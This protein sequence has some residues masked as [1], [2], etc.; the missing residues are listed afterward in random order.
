M[1][2]VH[3]RDLETPLA[4]TMATLEALAREGKIR[5]VGV[6]NF[7]R[8]ELEESATRLGA[9]PLAAAQLEYSLLARQIEGDALP[10]AR[11]RSVAVLAY[12]PLAHGVLAG[13][14]LGGKPLPQDW[15]RDTAYFDRGNL[16]V[17]HEALARGVVPVARARGLD[18][19]QV[20]L[21]WVLAQPGI[22]GVIAGAGTPA[23]AVANAA[24]A[25]A[26]LDAGE[27]ELIS[28]TFGRVAL[29]A[30]SPAR[31][32]VVTRVRSR[33]RLRSFL[34]VAAARRRGVREVASLGTRVNSWRGHATG[35]I[36]MT[37]V[38]AALLAVT[39][40][41][42]GCTAGAPTVPAA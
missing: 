22:T 24:A 32:G 33:V 6:S 10:W 25:E 42:D 20:C 30:P 3:H 31:A 13:R 28:A 2:Q 11:D 41:G 1:L 9:V 39:A 8:A 7:S 12:S 35:V 17:I 26:R 14:Q 40:L 16:G 37:K 5:A 29:A 34:A 27:V 23:Q 36:A 38:T 4:E 21:A 18:V 19:A 15:R